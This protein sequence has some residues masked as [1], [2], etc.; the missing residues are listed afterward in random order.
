MAKLSEAQGLL[1][2]ISTPG[3]IAAFRVNYHMFGYTKGLSSLLQGSTMDVLTAYN[4]I[5]L[6]KKIFVTMRKDAEKEFKPIL[7]SMLAMAEVAGSDGMPV[8]R[9]CLRLQEVTYKFQ[10]QNNIGIE[11][12]TFHSY[13]TSF[14]VIDSVL[15][16]SED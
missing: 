1:Q 8:P 13:I 14:L 2:L 5:H 6:V 7:D 16:Q 3:F 12:C 4:E 15:M 10:I 9:I 11:L